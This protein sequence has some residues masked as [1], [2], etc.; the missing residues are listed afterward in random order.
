MVTLHWRIIALL[1]WLTFFFNVERVHITDIGTINLAPGTYIIGVLAALLPLVPF[2]LK[3]P[4]PLLVLILATLYV[5]TL[6]LS[7]HPIFGGIYT[8]LTLTGMFM[9]ATVFFLSYQ[10]RR[11]LEEFRDAIE[12]ITFSDKG[13]HLQ[14]I[15]EAQELV[16][17]EIN[18]S[19]R[20]E[21]PLSVMVFQTDTS[22]LNMT[23]HRLVQEVQRSMMQR[24]VLSMTAKAFSRYLRRTDIIF[25]DH[26]PGR[27]ILLTPEVGEG[28]AAKVGERIARLVE[29]RLGVTVNYSF[30]AFPQQ[31]L[32][33][34]EL[35]NVADQRLQS[36]SAVKHEDVDLDEKMLDLKEVG[37][38]PSV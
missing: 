35:L 29:E 36:Q 15:N 8:Y 2:P 17:I 19:R 22:S 16:D 3:R 6:L 34:E 7:S 11:A 28:E 25:E 12:M 23:M 9:L 21:R 26:K 38:P 37:A 24:Y 20:T 32:T 1:A 4:L 33:F 31:A 13:R 18:R 27:L 30:A 5:V 14:K 10:V